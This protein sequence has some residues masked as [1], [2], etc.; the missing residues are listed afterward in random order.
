MG[1]IANIPLRFGDGIIEPGE[2]VPVE[3]GRS[4]ASMLRLGQITI[5]RDR[6][7]DTD[8]APR[9]RRTSE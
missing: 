1:Y 7:P 8:A 3:R 2:E 9:R 6:E 5:V 4:Y